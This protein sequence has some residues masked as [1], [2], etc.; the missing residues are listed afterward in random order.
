MS[1]A[2]NP[3][4]PMGMSP[5]VWGPIFWATMHIVTLGY[6]TSPSKEEQTAITAFFE[7][8]VHAIPCPICKS[9]YAEA[10]EKMPIAAV[11][12]DRD[13]LIE[14]C[15]NLHN[16]VNKQLNS[17]ELSW[18]DYIKTM[19]QLAKKD[20]LRLTD[21]PP[22]FSATQLRN[23]LIVGGVGIIIGAGALYT[24]QKFYK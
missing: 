24:F 11:I 16:Y 19:A 2:M 12:S 15:F 13:A 1:K 14:W 20:S 4:P 9:H 17:A 23:Y 7:S 5:A 21:L 8:L 6:S 18:P 10:L 3:F 22:A